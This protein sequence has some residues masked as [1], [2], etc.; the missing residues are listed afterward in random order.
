MSTFYLNLG[1]RVVKVI[2]IESYAS[3][4]I[5][6]RDISNFI[7]QDDEQLGSKRLLLIFADRDV[8]CASTSMINLV[9]AEI[10]SICSARIVSHQNLPLI[11][12]IQHFPAE[13]LQFGPVFDSLPFNGWDMTYCDSF[14]YKE[15]SIIPL[16]DTTMSR[17]VSQDSSTENSAQEP[18]SG[19]ADGDLKPTVLESIKGNADSRRWLQCAFGLQKIPSS[20]D[21]VLEFRERYFDVLRKELPFVRH[22]VVESPK[23]LENRGILLTKNFY[24]GGRITAHQIDAVMRL[25]MDRSYVLDALLEK[26]SLA[27]ASQMT[28]YVE[29]VAK[30]QLSGKSLESMLDRINASFGLLLC[31][32]VH[33]SIKI[34][35]ENYGLEA[36][37]NLPSNE[38]VNCAQGTPSVV[39]FILLIL[40]GMRMPSF[41]EL[42]MINAA[43]GCIISISSQNK[44]P[45]Q[46]PLFAEL[47]A[48]INNLY[49][50]VASSKGLGNSFDDILRQM[51]E[52]LNLSEYRALRQ[53]V[54]L[55]EGDKE[56]LEMFVQD[57]VGYIMGFDTSYKQE[58]S[59]AFQMVARSTGSV[60]RL[61]LDKS[62]KDAVISALV[63]L[64]PLR[65]LYDKDQYSNSIIQVLD[66]FGSLEQNEA[67]QLLEKNVVE[68]VWIYFV[69][70]VSDD[71]QD[72]ESLP[73][74]KWT[75]A[76][77]TLCYRFSNWSIAVNHGHEDSAT[78]IAALSFIANLLSSGCPSG[79]VAAA[80]KATVA[81]ITDL[82]MNSQQVLR[83]AVFETI[84]NLLK[85]STMGC[86]ISMR[87]SVLNSVVTDLVRWFEGNSFSEAK[88]SDIS[89]IISGLGSDS[90]IVFSVF[91]SA[92]LLQQIQWIK[93]ILG[94]QN[95]TNDLNEEFSKRGYEIIPFAPYH[96][97]KAVAIVDDPAIE[98]PNNQGSLA[99]IV[100]QAYIEIVRASRLDLSAL[101]DAFDRK[102]DCRTLLLTLEASAYA[103]VIVEESAKLWKPPETKAYVDSFSDHFRDVILKF[104]PGLNSYFLVCLMAAGGIDDFLDSIDELKLYGYDPEIYHIPIDGEELAKNAR[105]DAR[106]G[107]GISVCPHDNHGADGIIWKCMFCCTRRP[108]TFLC[109]GVHNYCEICHRAPGKVSPKVHKKNNFRIDIKLNVVIYFID[110]SL[111][112]TRL[113]VRW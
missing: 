80:G 61:V 93:S 79:S 71:V 22:S 3:G 31:S 41:H 62:L 13:S 88:S 96:V 85:Q 94:V 105:D 49:G 37:A 39:R 46:L 95:L 23:S 111:Q 98:V 42:R 59:V 55:V 16:E 47:I 104:I 106:L 26:F 28:S 112:S 113:C 57:T 73:W 69:R 102:K 18:Y 77:R 65:H 58:S 109:G 97:R 21:V 20:G 24:S 40:S 10:N 68:D 29:D 60:L 99:S 38:S 14:G 64:R 90:E 25:L 35:C 19:Q 91:S 82:F 67:L 63:A 110:Y 53:V 84:L 92:P 70:L 52:V 75:K 30:E 107:R 9:M 100:V 33:K 11:V 4:D 44:Y 50:R 89:L 78:R 6:C 12:L 51:Q 66:S 7:Q 72:L 87:A 74:T 56:L 76:T 34:M 1:E 5:C 43:A 15:S 81:K 101:H 83:E 48:Q 27:W 45:P 103:I 54:E 8:G 2:K 86:E 36:L 108:S 17:S 32:F